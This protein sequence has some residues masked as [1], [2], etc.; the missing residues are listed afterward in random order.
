[1]NQTQFG[2]TTSSATALP[3]GRGPV[4]GGG[5]QRSRRAASTLD[6]VAGGKTIA[7]VKWFGRACPLIFLQSCLKPLTHSGVL[8]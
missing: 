5:A 6:G 2:Q 7:R 3:V 4:K 1:M 8:F